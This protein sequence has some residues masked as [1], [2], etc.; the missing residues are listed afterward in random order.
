MGNTDN[1]QTQGELENLNLFRTIK[2][3]YPVVYNFIPSTK[4][5]RYHLKN[6]R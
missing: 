6:P 2:D 1:K 4:S 5:S 3:I